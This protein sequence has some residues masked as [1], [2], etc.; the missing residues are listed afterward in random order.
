MRPFAFHRSHSIDEAVAEHGSDAATSYLAGGTTLID[1]VKLDV[2]QPRRVVDVNRLPLDRIERLP[3]GGLKIGALVRNSDLAWHEDVRRQYPL[4]S[5]ALL[6]GA[7]PQLRNMATTGGNL[8]QRTRCPYFRDNISSCNK[9]APGS[10]CAAFEGYNRGHAIL[11]GSEA[12]IATHP[13]DMCV[14]LAALDATIHVRGAEGEH[15]IPFSDFHRLPGATPEVEHALR[16]GELITAVTLPP[17]PTGTRSQYLKLRDR[18][19]YEFALVS[20]AAI[21]AMNGPR[22]REARIALG[23]VGTK[24]WRVPAAEAVLRGAVPA[25]PIFKAAAE[26]ALQGAQ[27]REH[28]AFKLTLARHA[29]I[30]VLEDLTRDPATPS[31]A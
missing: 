18:E 5:A 11:G 19:S 26:S 27:P 14:A 6:S 8:M 1:L 24:P 31:V 12:C 10:G 28:N 7:S 20:V 9:R 17:P 22:I 25:P 4:L 30:R 2:M 29:I 13:S 23:G 16:P 15:S 3:D 21:I